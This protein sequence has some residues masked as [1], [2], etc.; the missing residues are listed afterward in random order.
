MAKS[1]VMFL[2]CTVGI[3]PSHYSRNGTYRMPPCL[4]QVRRME[5]EWQVCWGDA[6]KSVDMLASLCT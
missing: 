1:N 3:T 6:V 4:D 2:E 5:V